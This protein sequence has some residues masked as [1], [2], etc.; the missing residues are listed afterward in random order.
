MC[1]ANVR[2]FVEDAGQLCQSVNVPRSDKEH[3]RIAN[4][5]LKS[6]SVQEQL[7]RGEEIL[8]AERAAHELPFKCQPTGLCVP[9]SVL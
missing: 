9:V 3:N 1:F 8:H 2:L 6:D 4:V 7:L 5:S